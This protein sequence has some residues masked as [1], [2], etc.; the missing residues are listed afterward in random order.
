VPRLSVIVPIYD[1]EPYLAACLD[2]L[3]CQTWRDLEVVMVDDGS[4]DRSAEIAAHRA[5]ADPRFRLIRQPNAGLGAARNAGLRHAS[6]EFLAFLDSDDLAPPHAL[7]A[8]AVSLAETGSDFAAGNVYRFGGRGRRQAQMHKDAFAEQASRTHVTHRPELLTDRLVTNKLWRR[9]FWE[10][11]GLRFPEGVFYEDIAVAL[12]AHFLARSVDVLATTVYLWRERDGETLSITQ[13]RAHV[14][15]L[16]DRFAAVRSVRRFLL[17]SDRAAHV[18]TWDRTVLDSDLAIFLQVLDQGDEAFRQCFLD[19][20]ND[21]LDAVRPQV[22]RALP[23]AKRVKWRLVRERRLPELLELLAWE[24]ATRPADRIVRRRG[25]YHLASP[26]PV[27]RRTTRIRRELEV[28]QRVDDVRWRSGELVV[29]GRVTLRHL[30]PAEGRQR[31]FAWLVRADTGRRIRV[32][33]TTFEADSL[34]ARGT[35]DHCGFRLSLDPVRLGGDEAVWHVELWVLHRGVLRKKRLATPDPFPAVGRPRQRERGARSRAWPYWTDSGELRLRVARERARVTACTHDGERLIISGRLLADPGPAPVLRA[36]R[37]QGG[38]PRAYPVEVTGDAFRVTLDLPDLLSPCP[39]PPAPRTPEEAALAAG[40]EWRFELAERSPAG[41]LTPVGPITTTL[42]RRH[43]FAGRD[44]V[45]TAGGEG[46]LVLREEALTFQVDRAEWTAGGVL[47]LDGAAIGDGPASLVLSR[48]S[49]PARGAS[50]GAAE[51]T[52]PLRPAGLGRGRATVTLTPEEIDTLAGRLPLPA[53]RYGMAVRTGG[54]ELRVLLET[55]GP[56]AHESPR[57]SFDLVAGDDGGAVLV[58]GTD[59]RDGERGRKA[60]RFLREGY[61]PRL[62]E[63]RALRDA[64]FFDSGGGTRYAGDPRAIYEELLARGADLDCL[65]NVRDG[66][67]ALPPEAVAVRTNGR[68]Y[69]EAL[70]TCRY[71]VTDARL[72]RWFRRAEGQVVLRAWPDAPLLRMGHDLWGGDGDAAAQGHGGDAGRAAPRIAPGSVPKSVPGAAPGSVP[73]RAA[74]LATEVA[75]WSHLLSPSPWATPILRRALRFEGEV[76]ETGSP[77]TD[78]LVHR[79]PTAVLRWRLGL[80]EDRKVV[81]YAPTWPGGGRR[82][83]AS[84][85]ELPLDVDVLRRALGQDHVLLVRRHPGA[86]GEPPGAGDGFVVD[87]TGFPDVQELYLL[88]DVLVTDHS[89]AVFDFAATGRPILF[90]TGD[91]ERGGGHGRTLD[92]AAVAPG[93]SLRTAGEVADA[94]RRIDEVAAEYA[95]AYAGFVRGCGAQADGRAAARVV[96]RLFAV[97]SEGWALCSKE[98]V[99]TTYRAG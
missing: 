15:G 33:V 57:R 53:G 41:R 62:R 71:I 40:A 93:P 77:R 74:R 54:R 55:A 16:A 22:V 17:D 92:L 32:P 64:V 28:R 70:A 78:I 20:A 72:P 50:G 76:L 79:P 4:P 42:A 19:L 36:T 48:R 45:V 21:Y 86:T 83:A 81:L 5:A 97:G 67:A 49:G 96:D 51:Y 88:A 60:R 37:A 9:S 29:E 80:P 63:E 7:E 2:S 91:P 95:A 47:R 61:Y 52:F 27:P 12:P 30:V 39:P 26:V 99:R 94:L 68:E 58:V 84:R 89:P 38:L 90:L 14:K 66:Q 87:V 44:L 24:R 34:T 98:S 18:P 25:S 73:R 23:A 3:A 35:A 31:V 65:W 56:V 46:T 69:Y 8:M 10:R 6:G 1:V 85:T 82:R 59:L 75:Q 11:H 13:D 43:S